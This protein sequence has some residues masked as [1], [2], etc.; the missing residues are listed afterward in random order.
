MIFPSPRDSFHPIIYQIF[1]EAYY[2]PGTVVSTYISPSQ[3]SCGRDATTLPPLQMRKLRHRQRAALSRV[4]Q[5]DPELDLGDS[6][7]PALDHSNVLPG[8]WKT[9]AVSHLAMALSSP[10]LRTDR[11]L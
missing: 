2:V 4:P 11:R 6:P 3:Q 1:I 10:V 9:L 8:Q 5:P 7:R